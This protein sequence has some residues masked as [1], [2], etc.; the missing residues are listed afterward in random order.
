MN[1]FSSLHHYKKKKFAIKMKKFLSNLTRSKK[2]KSFHSFRPKWLILISICL[3]ISG[4]QDVFVLCVFSTIVTV[5]MLS[6]PLFRPKYHWS[7]YG[8]VV[9]SKVFQ[10]KKKNF[11]CLFF[12]LITSLSGWHRKKT[13]QYRRQ[14]TVSYCHYYY[15]YCRCNVIVQ[16]MKRKKITR[17]LPRQA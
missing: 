4:N 15:Y 6:P 1:F 7:S 11:F 2:K 5:Q 17:K 8:V 9:Y 10:K 12:W 13:E 3:Y 14:T 16:T